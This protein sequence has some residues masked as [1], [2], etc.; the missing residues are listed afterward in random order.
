MG[1]WSPALYSDDTTAEIRDTFKE[2][3]EPGLTHAD[4]SSEILKSYK[5]LLNDYQIACLVYFALA[6]THWKYG[7]LDK[8]VKAQALELIEAGGDLEIW[9]QES[10]NA[11]SARAK[12]LTALRTKLLSQ[13][14][15]LK[16][17]KLKPQKAALKLLTEPLGS[18]FSLKLPNNTIALLKFVGSRVIGNKEA[19]IFRILPGRGDVVPPIAQIQSVAELWVPLN[20]HPEFLFHIHDGRKNPMHILT[21]TGLVAS[22]KTPL[23]TDRFQWINIE[24]LP[25]LIQ[26]ALETF[27]T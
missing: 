27:Q 10:S 8:R 11:V 12:V 21:R 16:V 6:D 22:N 7:C 5:E 2:H 14:P 13:Q 19:P 17:L 4:A 26:K 20:D 1:A 18:I 3:L 9:R 25:A 15:P 23:K 24:F